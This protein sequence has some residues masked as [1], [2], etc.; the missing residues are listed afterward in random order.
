MFKAPKSLLHGLSVG[1]RV[2]VTTDKDR[3]LSIERA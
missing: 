3:I 1:E 2:T